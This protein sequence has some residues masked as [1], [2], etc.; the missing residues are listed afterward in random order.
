M[1]GPFQLADSVIDTVI[2]EPGS[3]VFLL[4]RIEETLEH[5]YYRPLVGRTEGD[6]LAQTLKGWVDSDYRV[7]WFEYAA[8]DDAAFEE[9]CRMWHELD[10]PDGKLDNEAHPNA[11]GS[12]TA[13]CPV[14]ST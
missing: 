11:S 5:A 3:A 7:F 2:R 14:C 13:R 12:L 8:S 4:R 10:G 9:E 6:D 1:D